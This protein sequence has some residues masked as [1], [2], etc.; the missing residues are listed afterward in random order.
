LFSREGIYNAV[1]MR[2]ESFFFCLATKVHEEKA[3]KKNS[4]FSVASVAKNKKK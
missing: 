1:K 2:K 3:A 4:V